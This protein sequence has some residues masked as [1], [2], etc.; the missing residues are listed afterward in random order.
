ML[1]HMCL[2][3]LWLPKGIC[4]VVGLDH[5]VILFLVFLRTLLRTV[6]HSGCIILHSHQQC[7]RIPFSPYLLQLLLFVDFLM[8][9][10]LKG[11]R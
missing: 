11:V 8:I 10:I 7:K 3:Q 4:P 6:L 2:L 5:V 9:T 1:G